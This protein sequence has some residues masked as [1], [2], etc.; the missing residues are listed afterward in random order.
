MT[1]Y[2][3]PH[4]TP[5]SD[6]QLDLDVL[7]VG[8]GHAGI[9]AALAGA[10]L[11]ARVGL[12]TLDLERVGEMSCNPAI[13]GLGKGQIVREIDALGGA[14]GKVADATG[15]QF[16]ILNTGKGAAVQAPRCQSDRHRYRQEVTAVVRAQPGL[17]LIA[18]GAQSLLL[19]RAADGRERVVGVRTEAGQELRAGATILTTGTFMGAVMHTGEQTEAGGRVGER[20]VEGLTQSLTSLGLTLGRLKTG[21]PPRLDGTTLNPERMEE[22]LGDAVPQP[23]S[24]SAPEGAFPPL[25]Q[26]PC[27]ITYTTDATHQIIA[28]NIHRAP[29]Y[30]G[31]IK[32]VGPRYCP[33]VEDK[34][35]RFPDRNR[36][37]IFVEPEGLDTNV[38]YINGVSTSLPAE[39]QEA[40]VRTIPGLEEA[41]FECFGYAV[42]YDFI[43]PSQLS[44]T[45]AV[46]E[47]PGLFLAGQVNGT[48]GYEEAAGQGLLAGTNAALWLQGREPFVLGRHEAYLGV[49]VDDLILTNPSEPYRMFSSRA[50]YRLL[51]RSD[52]ADRRLTPRAALV[53]LVTG[54][55]G[56]GVEAKAE[57]VRQTLALLG[58]ER[59]GGQTLA[60]ILRRPEV[61]L[62]SLASAHPALAGLEP[63]L[64]RTVEVEVKYAGYIQRQEDNVR[65]AARQENLAIPDDLDYSLLSGL[66]G[67]AREKLSRIRPATLGAAGRIEGV[68][69][70]DVALLGVH[71][72]RHRRMKSAGVS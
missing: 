17:E 35:M 46:R 36:H 19:S 30:A 9:E 58:S 21:T 40:F 31:R 47:V 44:H 48:S 32:G 63:D 15:I 67:E 72:E 28:D 54:E 57:R 20:S 6:G 3:H 39:V 24:F 5:T 43:Q 25:P 4:A 10:R 52:N 51:L 2:T 45:L 7:V 37:Q 1:R 61:T 56:L 62:G 71:V 53:G 60:E 8:G 68:R 14:M 34:I 65:R 41:R 66:G 26:V 33:S 64:A 12:L 13:G 27:H 29:M 16:R 69:P 59:Q 55:C 38:A 23:F 50:E 70:P 18:G 11:G 42:E 49:M 22:Q